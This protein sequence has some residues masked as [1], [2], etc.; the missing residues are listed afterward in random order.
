MNAFKNTT[1]AIITALSFGVCAT[2]ASAQTRF[3]AHHPRRAEVIE[4]AH[5]QM[6]RIHE[7]REAGKISARQAHR[8]HLA[9]HRIIRHEH[10]MALRHGGHVTRH[11]QIR[12]NREENRIGQHIPG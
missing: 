4:R 8:M 12:L 10:R 3:E 2:A 7:A 5:H 6:A 11:E 1:L 9:E